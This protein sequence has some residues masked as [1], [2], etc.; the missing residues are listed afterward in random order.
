MDEDPEPSVASPAEASPVE[1][2]PA[3]APP[4]SSPIDIS[5][6][7]IISSLLSEIVSKI[8]DE[9]KKANESAPVP[10]PATPPPPL[11]LAGTSSA[12]SSSFD[13]FLLS[14]H[15]DSS[16]VAILMSNMVDRVVDVN[17]I[18]PGW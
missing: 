1:A 11:S 18:W 12:L 5:D 7:D 14:Y 15:K 3:E 10:R 4:P 8:E 13:D 2:S 9:E 16:P 17:T 6:H